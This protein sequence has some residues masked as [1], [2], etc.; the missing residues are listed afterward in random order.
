MKNRYKNKNN[1]IIKRSEFRKHRNEPHPKYI[2]ERNN[3][4]YT[5]LSMTHKAPKDKAKDYVSLKHS[6][7]PIDNK[8]VYI[9]KTFESDNM[10]NFGARK[11]GWFFNDVDKKTVNKIIK[12]NKKGK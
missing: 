11:K 8:Q 5:Y 10:K 6:A 3:N 7:N 2:F 1:R 12:N 9:S 4:N